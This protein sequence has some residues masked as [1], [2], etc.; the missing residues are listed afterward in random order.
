MFIINLL[1]ILFISS[2]NIMEVSSREKPHRPIINNNRTKPSTPK[3]NESIPPKAEEPAQTG[4][5]IE[6]NK[7]E[8]ENETVGYPIKVKT[9]TKTNNLLAENE[10]DSENEPNTTTFETISITSDVEN[11]EPKTKKRLRD[12]IRNKMEES[13]L[14]GII[15]NPIIEK[16]LKSG[17]GVFGALLGLAV[18]LLIIV[19]AMK[20]I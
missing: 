18:T 1:T 13:G 9:K 4:L 12:K 8:E 14:A 7:H 10:S 2:Y 19:K 20:S 11:I 5:P 6:E 15:E 16:L 17:S 3:K